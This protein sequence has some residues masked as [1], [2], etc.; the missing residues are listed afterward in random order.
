MTQNAKSPQ[1]SFGGCLA[2]DFRTSSAD[3]AESADRV[4]VKIEPPILEGKIQTAKI[5]KHPICAVCTLCAARLIWGVK[6]PKQL[7]DL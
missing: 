7:I 3:S 1:I 6:R 2:V 5:N 4:N